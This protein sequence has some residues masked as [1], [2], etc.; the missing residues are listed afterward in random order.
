MIRKIALVATTAAL[1]FGGVAAFGATAVGAAAAPPVNA[2][3]TASCSATGKIKVKPA[4]TIPGTG[5]PATLT[6][7]LTIAGCTGTSGVLSG[8]GTLTS[9]FPTDNCT[10]LA[11]LHPVTTGTI[12]WKGAVK[13]NPSTVSFS[14]SSSTVTD[15]VTLH[16]PSPGP[17]PAAGTSSFTGSFAGQHANAT[18]VLDQH[19]ADLTPLC[20]GKGI[21]KLSFSGLQGVSHFNVT[22]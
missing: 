8:K 2:H 11:T 10:A 19:I 13:V 16:L 1:A 7:K 9:T 3:G 14:N 4:L 20:S 5:A 22:L 15:P 12:K 18:F 21:K 6:V 17:T